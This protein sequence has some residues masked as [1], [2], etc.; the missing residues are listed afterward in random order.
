MAKLAMVVFA[1]Y[2]ADIR[3]R[4]EAEALVEMGMSVDVI[5]LKGD[6]E[7][8]NEIVDGV[9]IY[10]LPLQRR[11][12]RKL[13]YIWEYFCF[14]TLSFFSLSLLYLR[15]QYKVIHVH[16]MP[17]FLVFSSLLP[18]LCGSKIILDLHDPMPEVFMAKYN[19]GINHPIIRFIIKLEKYSIKYSDLVITPNIAFLD[20]FISRGCPKKKI[21][22]VMNSPQEKFFGKNNNQLSKKNKIDTKNFVIIY[23]G[24]IVERNG[25][26]IALK[27]IALVRN[28]IPNI[29]FNVYGEGDFVNRF[30]ELVGELNLKDIV[31][32]HGQV[33]L[34]QIVS[35]IQ[36]SDLGLIPNKPSIHWE[37]AVPTRIFEYLSQRVPVIAP[38]TRGINDYFCEESIFFS[39]PGD[40][41]SIAQVILE[42][43]NNNNDRVRVVLEKGISIYKKYRWKL[44]RKHFVK[45]VES[46]IN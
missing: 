27:A 45:I 22:L 23:N 18:R 37:H 12:T 40:P 39:E 11:R 16:N 13:R 19:V 28:K 34:K 1:Y 25:I 43:Y 10:R 44:Q 29:V 6:S 33:P 20:L 3:V 42:V 15:N 36:S 7:P 5:C 46:L 2:P 30:L 26:D 4:R 8:K 32:Y 41:E 21:Y 38:R 35:S 9:Q 31:N 24:A 17:D 14:F